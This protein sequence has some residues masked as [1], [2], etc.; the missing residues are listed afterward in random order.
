M[1]RGRLKEV[2]AAEP[3]LNLTI[4]SY[5]IFPPVIQSSKQFLSTPFDMGLERL[6]NL[7]HLNAS[8][9]YLG[10]PTTNTTSG[11]IEQLY[12]IPQFYHTQW[13]RNGLFVLICPG[14]AV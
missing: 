13:D 1:L 5:L 2:M 8:L 10:S 12:R 6:R 14:T 3:L 9:Y 4:V 11:M 7:Y